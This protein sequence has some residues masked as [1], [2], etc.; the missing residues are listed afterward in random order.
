MLWYKKVCKVSST[1]QHTTI[2]SLQGLSL[3]KG[4]EKKNF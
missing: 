2:P 1:V 3:S 4:G